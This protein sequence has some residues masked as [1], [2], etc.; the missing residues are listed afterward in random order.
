MLLTLYSIPVGRSSGRQKLPF[1]TIHNYLLDPSPRRPKGRPT[2]KKLSFRTI[3]SVLSP[4]RPE[5]RPTFYKFMA[6][7]MQIS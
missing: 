5:G 3:H 2:F 4:R 7:D 6:R 1:T